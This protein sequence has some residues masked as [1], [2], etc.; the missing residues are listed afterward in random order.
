MLLVCLHLNQSFSIEFYL[1]RVFEPAQ[2]CDYLPYAII[3]SYSLSSCPS[4]PLHNVK[5][6][7]LNLN[8]Q[9]L[10]IPSPNNLMVNPFFNRMI[11]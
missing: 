2:L 4:L 9:W 11:Q 7:T 1:H 8:N 6:G 3:H 10:T 5:S